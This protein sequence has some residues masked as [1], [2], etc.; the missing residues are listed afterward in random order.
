M[1]ANPAAPRSANPT[2][3]DGFASTEWSLVLAASTEGGVALERL[4]RAYWRPVYVY[5]RTSGVARGEA[6]DATQEFFADM[7]RRDW[8]KVVDR[9]RGS[10]RAFLRTSAKYFVA[11]LRRHAEAQKRGGGAKAFALD[12]EECER[13]LAQ[14]TDPTPDPARLYEKNWARCVIDAALAR[15]SAEQ[16]QAGKG[17]LFAQLKRYLLCAPGPGDYARIAASLGMSSGQV[18]LAVHR[19]SRRFAEVV[20]AE[21]AATLADRDDIEAEL[22]YLL[23]LVS[24]ST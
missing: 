9:E 13:E 20:R 23:Q 18:A 2:A 14:L 22:R 3:P 8:L 11:N 6:E 10:F 24:A 17:E 1:P 19:L 16:A 21:I 7:L 12:A 15:L 4:C 5:I